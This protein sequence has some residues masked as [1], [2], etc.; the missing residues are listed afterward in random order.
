[1]TDNQEVHICEY[2]CNRTAIIQFGNGKWC[3]SKSQNS[4]PAKKERARLKSIGVKIH[5]LSQLKQIKYV[6]LDVIN[7]QNLFIKL[8]HYVVQMIGIDVLDK[9]KTFQQ[10][11]Q[12]FG[13]I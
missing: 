8:G 13:L 4:C 3:C 9:K 2:G 1:M 5:Q 10:D 7:K 11:L 6:H 12:K